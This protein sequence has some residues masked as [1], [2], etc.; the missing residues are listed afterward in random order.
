MICL[1]DASTLKGYLKDI[2]P[3]LCALA[4]EAAGSKKTASETA[5]SLILDLNDGF[6]LAH[7]FLADNPGSTA[8]ALLLD[9][10]LRRIQ[11]LTK[12]TEHEPEV[13]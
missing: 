3:A 11:R 5:L 6:V 13:Y 10:Y 12:L 7:S 8:K 4:R 1:V 9:P 2:V